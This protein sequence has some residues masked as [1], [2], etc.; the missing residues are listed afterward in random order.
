LNKD[1]LDTSFL[2]SHRMSLEEALTG[3]KMFKERQNEVTRVVL[4]PHGETRH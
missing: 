3:Y 2:L 4:K 1:K